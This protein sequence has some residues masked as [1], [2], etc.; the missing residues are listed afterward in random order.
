MSIGTG[1]IKRNGPWDTSLEII[2]ADLAQNIGIRLDT[3]TYKHTG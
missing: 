3:G 2:E 1:D